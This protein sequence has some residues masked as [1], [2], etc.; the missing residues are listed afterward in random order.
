MLFRSL[1]V[2]F[3]I[4]SEATARINQLVTGRRGQLL[5]YDTRPG[6]DGWDEIEALI[7][8]AEMRGLIVELRS[9]TAGVGTFTASFHE[10]AEL[11][12]R[13]ADDV[14]QKHKREAA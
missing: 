4:P 12:G 6:W 1:K 7:P 10:L 13:M 8:Q 11:S 9:A 5:G 2:R 3:D 14:V